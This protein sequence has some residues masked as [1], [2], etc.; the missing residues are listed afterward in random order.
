MDCALLWWFLWITPLKFKSIWLNPPY[1]PRCLCQSASGFQFHHL[2]RS[3]SLFGV[4]FEPTTTRNRVRNQF[5]VSHLPSTPT[6]EIW[7]S[8]LDITSTV[9][10]KARVGFEPRSPW[11]TRNALSPELQRLRSEVGFSWGFIESCVLY[12]EKHLLLLVSNP[13]WH[14]WTTSNCPLRH[15][16]CDVTWGFWFG[17]I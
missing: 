7:A 3:V 16:N 9:Y 13:A 2:Y 12:K 10:H 11:S 8:L 4:G 6:A 14:T 15:R 5:V 17:S 1:Q